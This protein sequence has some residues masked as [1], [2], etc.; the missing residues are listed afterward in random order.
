MPAEP[1]DRKLRRG[2][3]LIAFGSGSSCA[4]LISALFS[5]PSSNGGIT[6]F[7]IIWATVLFAAFVVSLVYAYRAG[8]DG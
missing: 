1:R 5:M 7:R 2:A 8:K 4:A 6:A 3:I